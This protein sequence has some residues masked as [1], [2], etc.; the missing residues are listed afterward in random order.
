MSKNSPEKKTKICQIIHSLNVGGAEHLLLTI[1]T[2]LYRKF[3]GKYEFIIIASNESGVLQND[4]EAAG[5]K[6]ISLELRGKGFIP[7]VWRLFLVLIKEKPDIVHTHLLPP[8]KYGQV[9]AF[10][11]L[12][13]KR[14]STVHSMEPTL[15]MFETLSVYIVKYLS[16]QQIAV[17]ASVGNNLI[18]RYGYNPGRI[19]VIYTAPTSCIVAENPKSLSLPI[20]IVILGNLKEAKGQEYLIPAVLE[21]KKV[22]F[23]FIVDII[24]DADNVYGRKVQSLISNNNLENAVHL[25]GKIQNAA[26]LIHGYSL[27]ISLSLWEGMPLSI[28]EGMCAGLPMILSDIPAHKELTQG[29]DENIFVRYDDAKGIAATFNRL[30]NDGEYYSW[31]SRKMIERSKDFTIHKMIEKYHLFY[32]SLTTS[33]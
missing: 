17:S 20:K 26:Q 1:C 16:K 24:G 28:I 3:P 19:N 2:E 18:K 9:A 7:S 5:I 27:M 11:A 32:Q 25:R 10:F 29:I 12:I 15:I 13:K 22:R 21:M 31:I 14:V 6:V 33:R 23:D 8:D 30:A 4:F